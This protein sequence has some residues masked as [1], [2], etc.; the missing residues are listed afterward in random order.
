MMPTLQTMHESAAR[1]AWL[2]TASALIAPH[3]TKPPTTRLRAAPLVELYG[4]RVS[5]NDE[6]L[7]DTLSLKVD[8]GDRVALVGPNGS[9][10]STLARLLGQRVFS[11]GFGQAPEST[12]MQRPKLGREALGRG[13]AELRVEQRGGDVVAPFPPPNRLGAHHVSFE[14]H[15]SLL[16][17]EAAEFAESRFSV[18]HK[19]ATVAS[20]LFPEFYPSALSYAG[21]EPRR[22]RPRRCPW[23][24]TRGVMTK[25][26]KL[27]T[28]R[29]CQMRP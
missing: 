26:S 20:Y 22:T 6:T 19:R 7:I 12:A 15:R 29:R 13:I 16:A 1:I 17:E 14:A 27:W 2:A 5:A 18:V 24:A 8:K 11:G 3:Q 25:P 10:K 23:R 9:G 21:Y 28:P 4:E